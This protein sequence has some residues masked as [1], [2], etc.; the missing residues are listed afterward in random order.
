MVDTVSRK[1]GILNTEDIAQITGRGTAAERVL[2]QIEILKSGVEPV[3]LIK[4]ATIGDGITA[5]KDEEIDRLEAAYDHR[6]NSFRPLKFVPASGAASRMFKSL[7]ELFDELTR[8]GG[9]KEEAMEEK[10]GGRGERERETVSTLNDNIRSFAFT[11]DLARVMRLA[12]ESLDRALEARDWRLI[13]DYLLNP[14]GLN[15]ARIPKGMVKLHRYPPG[16]TT[17]TAF[18]EHLVEAIHYARGSDDVAR[19]HFT[20]PPNMENMVKEH[21]EDARSQ[22]EREGVKLRISCSI[23][24][25]ATDTIAV[26]VENAP[27]RDRAGRL[28]FRPGGHGALL[29]NLNEL[30]ED[31]ENRGDVIFI[32]NID[33]VVPDRLKPTTLRYKKALGGY[34]MEIRDKV[35]E[36]MSALS[37]SAVD[38]VTIEKALQFCREMRFV[39]PEEGAGGESKGAAASYLKRVLNRP[40]RVCGVV[41]NAGE[42]GGGPF[43]IRKGDGEASLQIVESAEVDLKDPSQLEVWRSGTHFNPV[44]IIC[45]TT[46][47][48]NKPFDLFEFRDPGRFFISVK[49][50]GGREVKVLEFPGLWNGGMAYWNTV[51]VEVPLT[52]F[53][54]VKSVFDLLKEEH[55]PHG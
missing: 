35:R 17:R 45:S 52:T 21:L 1:S 12:G 26:D 40:I 2:E 27:F 47:Y 19:V 30:R 51:F 42:P 8:R 38:A 22:Y 39:E 37:E 46:D 49:S 3:R 6:R 20:L 33:N 29:H 28:L 16:G 25:P 53:S 14:K 43:W 10:R 18:E 4:P 54:P 48:R 55:L 7:I 9:G 11:E 13:L 41:R 23:Q 31:G 44:D 24:D 32:K 5:L 34:L 36:F 15:Y 50:S